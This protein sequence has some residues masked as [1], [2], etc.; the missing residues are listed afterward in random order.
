ME[1][2]SN[3]V[4]ERGELGCSSWERAR[5]R[6]IQLLEQP[7]ERSLAMPEATVREAKSAQLHGYS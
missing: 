4:E 1:R 2:H 7:I 3:V 5:S 6:N